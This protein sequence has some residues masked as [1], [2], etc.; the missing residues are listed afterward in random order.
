MSSQTIG[1]ATVDFEPGVFEIIAQADAR[2]V[3]RELELQPEIAQLLGFG[4]TRLHH[5]V[6]PA[7][8]K[9]MS[10]QGRLFTAAQEPIATLDDVTVT[11]TK[12]TDPHTGAHFVHV[13]LDYFCT[14]H[15]WRTG[16]G[17]PTGEPLDAPQGLRFK[18]QAGGVIH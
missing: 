4:P 5:H 13:W 6:A 8:S 12:M 14:S 17:A 11:A 10:F 3:I 15:G 7:Q 18:N 1:K 9:T 16:R 2:P